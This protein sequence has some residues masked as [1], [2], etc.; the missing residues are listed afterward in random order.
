MTQRGRPRT[1]DRD[2]ALRAAMHVFWERGYENASLSDLTTAMGI[3]RPSLYAAFGDKEALFREATGLYQQTMN[4]TDDALAT[5]PTARAGVEAMLRS[6]ADAYC[7]PATPRGCLVVSAAAGCPDRET[8]VKQ[9]LTANMSA[10]GEAIRRRLRR[11]AEEGEI[12]ADV[13]IPGVASYYET[14]LQGLSLQA[15]NGAPRQRLQRII[16]CAMAGWD[17]LCPTP[18][19]RRGPQ[20]SPASAMAGADQGRGR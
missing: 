13:D 1:F 19:R 12:G 7:D 6:N 10:V 17:A 14:V 16:D 11:A 2:A 3:N 9:M 18:G 15:R 5:A 20:S 8:A 4:L